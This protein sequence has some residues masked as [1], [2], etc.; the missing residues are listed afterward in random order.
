MRIFFLC[1]FLLTSTNL[2]TFAQNTRK[3][4]IIY[5][6]ADDL[7]YGELG[8][9]GQHIIKTPNLDKLA[10][11]GMKF[12]QFYAGSAVCAPTRASLLTGKHL[13]NVQIR[14]NDERGGWTDAEE[15]GQ[16]PLAAN[17]MTIARLLKEQGYAT[18]LF[19]KWGLGGPNTEGVPN[20]HGFDEFLGYLDQKQA[21]N[22]YPSHLWHNETWHKLDNVYFSPHQKLQND[23]NDP[24]SYEAFK[25]NEYATDVMRD[26]A[27]QWIKANQDK[28]FFLYFAPSQPHLALQ[29]PDEEL[30]QYAHLPDSPYIG[31]KGY[32]PHLRPRSAY[33]G[34]ISRLDRYVG[35][36]WQAVK[37]AGLEENTVIFFTS[38]NGTTHIPSQA[39]YD[40]FN[41]TSGLRGLKGS[42]YEGGIRVP[43]IAYWKGKIRPNSTTHHVAASYDVFATLA[44]LARIRQI[45]TTDGISFRKTLLQ[46]R[47]QRKHEY[48]YW[49]IHG[50]GNG[51]QAVR[52]GDW[53]AVRLGVHKNSD[54]PIQLFNLAT[55]RNETTDVSAQQ[56]DIT[57]RMKRYLFEAHSPAVLPK[58]NFVGIKP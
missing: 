53:K 11:G 10:Q 15:R 18:A 56:P 47:G 46:Q 37:E 57:A 42:M 26:G 23:P 24:K 21:H 3:P 1:L 51:I 27:I 4:N 52:W 40:F 22:F 19:G 36:I 43:M 30:A 49:E 39:D 28:P 29:V 7:G 16:M 25:G 13:G 33:A 38:D 12:T 41:S 6:M 2:N 5:I 50:Y 32:L 20:K 45:P 8:A 44:E 55:D 58:W 31:D 9:Y 14:D 48:M 34:M 17:T 35:E 54:A